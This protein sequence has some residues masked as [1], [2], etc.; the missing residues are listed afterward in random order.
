MIDPRLDKH[1]A[2]S[3]VT[4]AFNVALNHQ[5]DVK[6]GVID[7]DPGTDFAPPKPL[8][9]DDFASTGLAQAVFRDSRD[10]QLAAERQSRLND[11]VKGFETYFARYVVL[12]TSCVKLLR[13]A[14]QIASEEYALNLLLVNRNVCAGPQVTVRL[15]RE[16]RL[17]VVALNPSGTSAGQ[18]D[19]AV[20]AEERRIAAV[21]PQAALIPTVDVDI[22]EAVLVD[23][24][25]PAAVLRFVVHGCGSVK[26][27]QEIQ[28]AVT[29]RQKPLVEAE[30]VPPMD[31]VLRFITPHHHARVGREVA[32]Q[33]DGA[34]PGERLFAIVRINDEYFPQ[35]P[36]T[37]Q[38]DGT[39][40][41]TAIVGRPWNDCGKSF[42]LRIFGQVRQTLTVGAP[43]GSW[44]TGLSASLP[45][46]LT[47]TE[48]CGPDGR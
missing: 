41:G 11:A 2:R 6:V 47:R 1:L 18:D 15:P 31:E 46:H 26:A 8:S 36:V 5:F 43:V 21:F 40:D 33:G 30:S 10:R 9:L 39:F 14:R 34:H 28:A 37:A 12:D 16:R 44:P 24:R 13:I 20:I 4:A 3:L 35:E 22:L 42:E 48:E 27:G 25:R 19:C 17:V 23:G 7:A 32:Y 45:V 38:P 29:P